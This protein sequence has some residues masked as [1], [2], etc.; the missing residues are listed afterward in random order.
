VKKRKLKSFL[1]L[2]PAFLLI[3]LVFLLNELKLF[4]LKKITCYLDDHPCSLEFEPYLV[5]L[6]G[7]NILKFDKKKLI[8]QLTHFD[9]SLSDFKIEKKL[10]NSLTITIKRRTPI[11][12]I[13]SAVDLVIF[14]IKLNCFGNY[15]RQI[16]QEFFH[17]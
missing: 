3:S 17:A 13:I 10:P 16:D 5:N 9:E 2:L 15:F 4:N 11:A 14:C 7:T 6:Y 1:I 12:K 8:N